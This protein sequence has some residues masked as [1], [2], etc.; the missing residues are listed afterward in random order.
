M[1]PLIANCPEWLGELLTQSGGSVSFSQFM[2]WALNEKSNGAYAT[3]RLRI[4]KNGDFVTS[5]SL[6]PEFA[7]LLA[8]QIVDWFEQI[9]NRSSIYLIDIGPGEGHLSRDLIRS[10]E[11]ISPAWL[12]RIQLILV[13]PNLGMVERQKAT[14]KD[15][16]I[17]NI[18]WKSIKELTENPVEGVIIA[19]EILDS[20]PVERLIFKDN[21]LYQQGISLL[22]VEGKQYIKYVDL[23]ITKE[24]VYSIQE[25]CK[26]KNF[27]IPPAGIKDGWST[28]WHN[29][30][31]NWFQEM[32]AILK[33]GILLVID[34]TLESFRYYNTSR[35]SGTLVA[36]KQNT[37]SADI[38]NEPGNWDLTSHI[39]LETVLFYAEKNQYES[40]GYVLQGQALLALGLAQ[41][42]HSLQYFPNDKL[43]IA[44]EKR[45][46]LLR[47]VDPSN[48]GRF[49]W[50]A[51]EK[52]IHFKSGLKTS[53]LESKFLN[54]PIN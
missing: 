38:L 45:E 33:N 9:Q 23:P 48:L 47:L 35:T 17:D 41:K 39:C 25:V 42:I 31:D 44:L 43:S 4:G 28:E 10:I 37:M 49:Y 24:L 29:H 22:E 3:G 7:E 18:S 14:L 19:H 40:L 50:M 53:K 54:E 1:E 2:D 15:L 6:G 13:E 26:S 21:Q 51:F 36:Y 16:P 5:P 27:T 46:S 12:K 34:Y 52:N 20:L 8:V 32:N 30:L 11:K